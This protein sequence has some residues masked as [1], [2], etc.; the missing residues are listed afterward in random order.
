MPTSQ[1]P[2]L[3]VQSLHHLIS[4]LSIKLNTSNY[5]IWRTQILPLIQSLGVENHLQEESPAEFTVNDK[6]EKVANSLFTTWKEKD[7]LLQSWLTGTLSEEAL[8]YVV[9]C[10]TAKDVWAVLE[11]IYYRPLR[12]MRFS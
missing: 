10:N 6:G 8:Y 5:L 12:I 4:I 3:P 7:L 9:G 1:A 11:G 2:S